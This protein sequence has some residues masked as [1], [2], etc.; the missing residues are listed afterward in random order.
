VAE[1]EGLLE[2]DAEAAALVR[3]LERAA[4]RRGVAASI[5]GPA[6]IGKTSLLAEAVAAA[7]ERGFRVLRGAGSE[8][9]SSFAF[10]V[11]GQL[12]RN[13][14]DDV[15]ALEGAAAQAPAVLGLGGGAL[16]EDEH[17]A[18][19]ALYWLTANLAEQR[20]TLLAV[21]DAQWADA[22]SLR[23]LHFLARRL[24]GLPVALV[25][26]TRPPEA[27][28][29]DP[30]LDALLAV[31]ATTLR[32]APLSDEAVAELVQR[33]L[34]APPDPEFVA[35]CEQASGGNA[36]LL[37]QL[38]RSLAADGVEPRAA[39]LAA[40]EMAA[41]D[42][43]RRR[44][45]AALASTPP[46]AHAL[47][48]ALAVL[49][50]AEAPVAAAVA[51]IDP[52]EAVKA[53]R[54]LERAALLAPGRRLRLA[55]PLIATSVLASMPEGERSDSH[56]RAARMLAEAG[57]PIDARAVH[58]LNTRPA[59]D[60]DV[61]AVLREAAAAA[62]VRGAPEAGVAYLRRAVV[63]PPP[64]EELP[65]LLLALG[66]AATRAGRFDEAV[67][68]LRRA[69]ASGPDS[70]THTEL[71]LALSRAHY[72]GGH[73]VEAME[74][75]EREPR[76]AVDDL[77]PRTMTLDANLFA[78]LLL[79]PE[80]RHLI[81]ERLEHYR[82]EAQRGAL[83]D[84]IML[85]L[86]GGSSVASGR[87]RE[88]GIPLVRRA[89]EED[90]LSGFGDEVIY[91]YGWAMAALDSADHSAEA[92]AQIDRA[93]AESRRHG[94]AT[95]TAFLLSY[96]ARA[97][98]RAGRVAE[99]EAIGWT[100]IDLLRGLEET[101]FFIFPLLDALVERAKVDEAERL[102]AAIPYA[103]SPQRDAMLEL[104]RGRVMLAAGRP[105]EALE[106]L[107]QCGEVFDALEIR[108][109]NLAPWRALGA[110]AAH[111]AGR[112]D[113][114]ARYAAEN[115]QI[116]K[117]CG[118]QTAIGRALRVHALVEDDFDALEE[119]CAVLEP[120]DD[121]LEHAYSLTELGTALMRRGRREE[122]LERLRWAMDVAHASG[123]RT[124]EERARK[125]LVAAGARPRRAAL[126]GVEALTG[127]ELQVARLA[128]E[129]LTNREIAQTLFV[130]TK[131]VEQHL[132]KAYGKLGIQ[133]R[134]ELPGKL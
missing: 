98:Y 47:A 56:A 105:A 28:V 43:V 58:L 4:K 12:F 113:D 110:V 54:A 50:E 6:G 25:V 131:T 41:P 2:R 81:E 57:A 62:T 5:E 44:V 19:H 106:L 37:E 93:L 35:A 115:L 107:V 26:A 29:T 34:G 31:V 127:S 121:G 33:R 96:Q 17:A 42:A 18:S 109:P 20:P 88:E 27:G 77:D 75:L 119:S 13:V 10:G 99:A 102:A 85:A 48:R 22:A 32:L 117:T 51:G 114:A 45:A 125:E 132:S 122:A 73:F 84:P 53:A 82:A 111:E 24:E 134:S 16:P 133:G 126:T 108:Q 8:L 63:E 69:L 64:A 90:R 11:V 55:H 65:G 95:L 59:A 78:L 72:L 71:V 94:A 97:I 70:E 92:I 74:A 40:V 67:D 80:R 36:F 39:S 91:A 100:A 79:D 21:D 38:L 68:A 7:E 86:I 30:L 60:Q 14:V 101:Q 116:S 128:A 87:P 52:S 130:T 89:L 123:A 23:F 83:D 103:G 9:E 118:A 3:L 46:A 15:G 76:G 104:M 120:T 112:P 49:G 66:T 124:I 1:H 61:V 129:G